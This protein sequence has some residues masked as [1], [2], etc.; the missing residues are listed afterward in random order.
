MAD[1]TAGALRGGEARTIR[2]LEIDT[3]ESVD[4]G[5]PVEC[6]ARR[7]SAAPA[8][9]LP[10]GAPVWFRADRDLL[11]PYDR[12]LLYLWTED[13]RFV[14]LVMVRRGLARAVLYEPN[15]AYIDV[16][17]RAEARAMAADRGL[18]GECRFFGQPWVRD[19]VAAVV[20]ARGS[21]VRRSCGTGLG[22]RARTSG[23]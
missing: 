16:M 19:A 12:T 8:R 15:D 11:D 2:L 17:R 14:N 3:P 5:A 4:P 13:G 20:R 10:V 22:P 1:R 23:P 18:W 9:M 6:Y 7:S 21:P